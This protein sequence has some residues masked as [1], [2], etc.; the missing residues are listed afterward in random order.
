MKF[1]T[2]EQRLYHILGVVKTQGG[3]ISPYWES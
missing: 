2:L 1:F 3:C